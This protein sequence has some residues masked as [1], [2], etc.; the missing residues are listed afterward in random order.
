MDRGLE[1][2]GP[3]VGT[4]RAGRRPTGEGIVQELLRQTVEI[5]L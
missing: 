2:A 1:A 4:G 5:T 3:C